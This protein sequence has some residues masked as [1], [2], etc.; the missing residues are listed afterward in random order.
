[1]T[2]RNSWPGPS[3]VTTTTDARIVHGGLVEDYVSGTPRAGIFPMN[4]NP[5]VTARSDMNVDIA[6]FQ[7]V[8]VQFG[9][10][11]LIANDGTI[12]LPAVLVS[13]ASGTN[14]Y[15]VYVKQDEQTSPG[16]DPDNLPKV[17]Q[18]LSTVSFAAARATLPTGALELATV[19]VPSGVA[20]TNASGV[21]ITPTFLYT[22]AEGGC[23]PV[24][25]DTELQAWTPAD[26]SEA[27]QIDVQRAF[28][29]VSGVWR[30]AGTSLLLAEWHKNIPAGSA[31]G[32]ALAASGST[33]TLTAVP[34]ARAIRLTVM[35]GALVSSNGD[36]GLTVT[37]STGAWAGGTNTH[38]VVT[39]ASSSFTDLAYVFY[40][41]S[42]PANT[43]LTLTMVSASS[44]TAGYDIH[45]TVEEF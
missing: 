34:Y 6:A 12:Q 27:Y 11:I 38:R 2:L 31:G 33:L 14:F 42:L 30:S 15:V 17:G 25:N 23:V 43:T 32:A 39:A 36:A 21:T 40:M 29:R 1:M 13:P 44:V 8:A 26:G 24:R 19:Q 20:A 3:G 4:L 5:I 22:V 41:A 9:G 18:V 7:G 10:P 28:R 45:F 35:G 37:P 16:T